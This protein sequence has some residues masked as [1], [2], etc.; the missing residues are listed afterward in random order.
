MIN[1][2]MVANKLV[3]GMVTAM[4]L[5]WTARPNGSRNRKENR[6]QNGEREREIVWKNRQNI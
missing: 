4:R 1:I 5:I 6:K 3:L 2:D